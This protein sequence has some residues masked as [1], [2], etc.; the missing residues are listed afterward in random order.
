MCPLQSGPMGGISGMTVLKFLF[1]Q[2]LTLTV[3]GVL[4]LISAAF[5]RRGRR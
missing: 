3:P 1:L 5:L 2:G 4:I